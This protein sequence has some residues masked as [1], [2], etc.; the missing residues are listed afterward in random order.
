MMNN[1][2][3]PAA[4]V[5]RQ[6][7][8]DVHSARAESLFR[9]WASVQRRAAIFEYPIREMQARGWINTTND[10]DELEMELCGFFGAPTVAMIRKV[11][12]SVREGRGLATAAGKGNN[13]G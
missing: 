6:P 5:R 12:F 4:A 2:S 10:T 8:E 11:P 7:C 1:E 9:A 3:L 13:Q